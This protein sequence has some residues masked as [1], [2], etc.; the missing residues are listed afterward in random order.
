MSSLFI[1]TNEDGHFY[2]KQKDWT[3]GQ[4]RS[5][6]FRV[7]HYDEALNTLLEL[8]SKDIE[9]RATVLEAETDNRGEPII[10]ISDVPLPITA[11]AQA[12][13]VGEASD[14]SVI[15]TEEDSAA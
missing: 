4:Q 8:N 1:I 11:T 14:T 3:D 9:L 5:A 12:E 2:S 6:I 7:K 13:E 10:T 15:T